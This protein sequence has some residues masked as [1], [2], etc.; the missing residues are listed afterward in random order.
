MNLS[1][2]ASE[3]DSFVTVEFGILSNSLETEIPVELFFSDF[4]NAQSKS[5][6]NK[7]FF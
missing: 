5:L 7:S 6:H 3:N 2:E 1:H 4:S